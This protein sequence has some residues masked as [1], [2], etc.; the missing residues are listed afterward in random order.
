MMPT[1]LHVVALRPELDADNQLELRISLAGDSRDKALELLRK[2][3]DSPR[4]RL[5]QLE[6][7]TLNP[8]GGMSFQISALYVPAPA[9]ASGKAGG[10]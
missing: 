9:A 1:R 10:R 5:P 3:E 8:D 6:S 2:M 7:E 4:F